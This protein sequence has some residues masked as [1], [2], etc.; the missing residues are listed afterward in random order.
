MACK[1]GSTQMPKG[2]IWFGLRSQED[3]NLPA[4]TPLYAGFLALDDSFR[5]YCIDS[6]FRRMQRGG[7][8]A[9]TDKLE[10]AFIKN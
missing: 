3:L 4:K 2:G 7:S 1:S 5:E 10:D 6:L 9:K 8:L